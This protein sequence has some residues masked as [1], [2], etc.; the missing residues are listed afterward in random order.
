MM[1]MKCIGFYWTTKSIWSRTMWTFICEGMVLVFNS[2]RM[3]YPLSLYKKKSN[4][5]TVS[6]RPC[7]T[8]DVILYYIYCTW[9]CRI[10]FFQH[11]NQNWL[12]FSLI[13]LKGKA[14]L[15]FNI[16][17]HARDSLEYGPSEWST[18]KY[19][20]AGFETNL[21]DDPISKF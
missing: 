20:H 13:E 19:L 14:A 2:L 11:K 15:N 5:P 6:E 12:N 7:P 10:Y 16:G 18:C 17:F 3:T 1:M 9:S 21:N 4:F 8:T